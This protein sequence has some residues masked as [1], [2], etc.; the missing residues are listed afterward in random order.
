[1]RLTIQIRK[2][3]QASL[4][5]FS[6]LT[7]PVISWANESN[8]TQYVL[9]GQASPFAGF[10]V[11]ES[12]LKMC[13]VATQDAIYYRDLSK[14]Q[15]KFYMQ[16]MADNKTIADLTLEIRT[17]EDAAVEKGL[18]AELRSKS[19]WWKQYWFTIPATALVFILSH[20]VLFP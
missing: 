20:G 6:I 17:K 10:I 11:E 13:V 2:L 8:P 15:E 18:K 3:L 14:L 16:K 7:F 4:I 12:R 9:K 1:M 5:I 19:V